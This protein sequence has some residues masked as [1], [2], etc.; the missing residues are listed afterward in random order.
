MKPIQ[1]TSGLT[2]IELLVVI[3]ITAFLLT[4]GASMLSS[5]VTGNRRVSCQ[6][7]L[8][9]LHQAIS[10]YMLDSDGLPPPFDPTASTIQHP[11]DGSPGWQGNARTLTR[12]GNL[13]LLA[14]H[15]YGLTRDDP[16]ANYL[17]G[18]KSLHCPEDD[19]LVSGQRQPGAPHCPHDRSNPNDPRQ[20]RFNVDWVSYQVC[21]DFTAQATNGN[22]IQLSG[23]PYLYFTYAW[24]RNLP[25]NNPEYPRQLALDRDN[26]GL[27]DAK[28]H[29]A[30]NTVVTWCI[31]HRNR[32]KPADHDNVLFMDGSVEFL[33]KE[34]QCPTKGTRVGAARLPER[35]CN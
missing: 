9:N 12:W 15:S 23:N 6:V 22:C 18:M 2:L 16:P 31:F 27:P 4:I 28:W 34:Q 5:S 29:P 8:H 7:N 1:R 26:N 21:D 10:Q 32:A 24:T 35:E 30:D 17:K 11:C 33:P 19:E 3:A 20:T 14:L 13:G 25:A